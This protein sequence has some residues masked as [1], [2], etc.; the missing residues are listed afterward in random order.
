MAIKFYEFS[1][2]NESNRSGRLS[3]EAPAGQSVLDLPF[4]P[5]SLLKLDP[6]VED[7]DSARL[8]FSVRN[9]D[10]F[11]E[12]TFDTQINATHDSN[13]LLN[14]LTA[15]RFQFVDDKGIMSVDTECEPK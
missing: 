3:L 6:F 15:L 1:F 7:A 8:I 9:G 13:P 11:S 12:L 2:T 5:G 4:N 10:N 14:Y